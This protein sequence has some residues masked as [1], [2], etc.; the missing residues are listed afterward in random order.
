[1]P[2]QPEFPVEM[3]HVSRRRRAVFAC[4]PAELTD[5]LRARAWKGG[6]ALCSKLAVFASLILGLAMAPAVSACSAFVCSGPDE[7]LLAKNFDWHFG[8][9][10]LVKNPSGVARRAL[11]LYG[12]EPAA[13]TSVHGSLTFTQFG[14]G[15]PY[16]GINQRGLAIEMLWLDETVYPSSAPRTIG[17]LE[18][19]QYQL[20][21]RASVAEVL[22]NVAE[23]SI[24]P[25]GG[26]IHYLLA[27]ASGDRA[28]VEFLDG[29]PRIHRG[30][31]GPLVCA[32]DSLALSELAFA[33]LRTTPLK[34]NTSRTRYARLRLELEAL[35]EPP[36]VASGWEALAKV[37]ESGAR[38][39]TQW[40]AIYELRKRRVHLKPD[41]AKRV[42]TLDAA[43]LDYTPGSGT[44]FQDL[45]GKAVGN[46]RFAPLT[47]AA[48]LAL[49][50]RNLPKVGLDTQLEAIA[51]HLLDPSASGVRPLVGRATLRVRVR[52]K[53]P[54]DFARIA[55]FG[56]QREIEGQ[57]AQH[58][59]SVLL[60]KA[61]REFGFYNL[62]KARYAVGAFHDLNQDGRLSRG[63]PLAYFHPDPGNRGTNFAALAFELDVP[64]RSLEVDFE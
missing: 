7:V 25:F 32:N 54:G 46:D 39:R 27:D 55:V 28:L 16:G 63:E 61:E 26:K 51:R 47:E 35:Q 24:R 49:L 53:A 13:W 36:S 50:R 30:G 22:A 14:A 33:K 23:F 19:I 18:W 62:P 34:G 11:P 8:G 48:N 17:E 3:L 40:S 44:A 64:E 56:S 5:F 9:G 21:T 31:D 2:A 20:D 59:G 37:A 58:A 52:A 1:M 4:E 15:L 57:T 41:Q 43:S 45:A 29:V 12:G 42:F 10:Y 38:Y 6:R 60:D